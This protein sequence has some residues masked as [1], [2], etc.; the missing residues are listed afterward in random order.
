MGHIKAIKP[1]SAARGVIITK[2]PIKPWSG[3]ATDTG[4]D[5]SSYFLSYKMK[6]KAVL[7][8]HSCLAAVG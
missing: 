5:F 2:T 4:K 8:Q 3:P 1:H 7:L 6:W